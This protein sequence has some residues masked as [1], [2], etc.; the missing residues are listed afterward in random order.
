M[1]I[2][3][4]KFCVQLARATGTCVLLPVLFS[5]SRSLYL[6]TYAHIRT[7]RASLRMI[8]LLLQ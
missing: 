1:H 3:V 7:T 4:L 5:L 6:S 8:N 2:H